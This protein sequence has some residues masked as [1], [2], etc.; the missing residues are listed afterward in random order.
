MTCLDMFR[1][2]GS[3]EHFYED[4]IVF[5]E[6]DPG[7]T[8]YIVLSGAFGVY[9]DSFTNF[10]IRV[11]EIGEGSFFGEMSV[12]DGSPRSAT[13]IAET[14][15]SAIVIDRDNFGELL[16]KSPTIAA[17]IFY[18]LQARAEETAEKV[19]AAGKKPP[20][21]S[22]LVDS[23]LALSAPEVQE[24]LAVLTQQIRLMNNLLTAPFGTEVEYVEL[25]QPQEMVKLLPEGHT[26]FGLEEHRNNLHKLMARRVACPYCAVEFEAYIPLFSKLTQRES[27]PDGRIIY[28]ELDILRYTNVIC[29]N[30]N[31]TDAYQEFHGSGSSQ[32]QPLYSGNQFINVEGFAGFANVFNRSV[33]ETILSYYLNIECLN[34]I[35]KNPL[36]F[37]RA[38]MR[39]HW[40]YRDLGSEEFAKHAAEKAVYY[41]DG[42]LRKHGAVISNNE[43]T[44]IQITL[45]E[46]SIY[47]GDFDRVREY[48]T[49][50]FSELAKAHQS[51]IDSVNSAGRIQRKLLPKD[52]AFSEA[53]SDYSV[54]WDPRD[55]IGGDMY[56][57]KNFEKGSV[58]CV[59][60]CTGH[61]VP[62]A[63]LTPIAVSAFESAVNEKNCDDT[64]EILW[65]LEQTIT[66]VFKVKADRLAAKKSGRDI[67]EGCDLAVLFIAKDGNVKI[68]SGITN[69]FVCDGTDVMRIKG[70]RINIGEG[71]LAGKSDV[72]TVEVPANPNNKFYIASDG[73]FDQGGGS[74]ALP[75]GYKEFLR[76]ILEN[77]HEKQSVISDKIWE[78]FESH[79]DGRQRWDDFELITFKP[80]ICIANS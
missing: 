33:D 58:L 21:I 32:Q 4:D 39:L 24:A 75:F 3:V 35:T 57:V 5:N 28:N 65:M 18:K 48:L 30:C 11:A 80:K 26:A 31:Y 54:I 46:L 64:A 47:L 62:G 79:R 61:G 43:K 63:L 50:S 14:D 71:K 15:G 78:A 13:I 70:Q 56:W 67:K 44:R 52:S 69:V 16:E 34:R 42:F 40:I 38:W 41:Y 55:V 19:Y 17:D 73:L 68:S 76:I 22:T 51:I 23:W 27:M 8:M 66:R 77:H 74:P 10:P 12:I 25:V 37:A 6:N 29:P 59:C 7:N 60:D 53:F 36:R 1:D 20:L 45:G 49:K 9:I 2:I 72:K